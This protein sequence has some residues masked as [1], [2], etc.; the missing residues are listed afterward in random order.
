MGGKLPG[1]GAWKAPKFGFALP[2]RDTITTTVF[3]NATY[4]SLNGSQAQ[5]AHHCL[6]PELSGE[7]GK[8]ERKEGEKEGG[9]S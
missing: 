7:A 1:M 3:L 9:E 2:P 8:E 6:E 5:I 4:S